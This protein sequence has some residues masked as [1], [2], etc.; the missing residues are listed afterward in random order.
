MATDE[1][2]ELL[3]SRIRRGDAAA[4]EECIARYEGRLLAFVESRLRNRA[5]RC[6]ATLRGIR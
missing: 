3:I 6:R 4:W 5:A 2:E 1:S